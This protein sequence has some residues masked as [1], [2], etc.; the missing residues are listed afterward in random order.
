MLSPG[1]API[2]CFL[3]QDGVTFRVR[4]SHR[5]EARPPSLSS[6]K[7]KTSGGSGVGDLTAS[8]SYARQGKFQMWRFLRAVGQGHFLR[9]FRGK[10]I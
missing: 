2:N 4:F 8:C 10:C 7:K 3:N 1:F 6:G 5:K 9:K